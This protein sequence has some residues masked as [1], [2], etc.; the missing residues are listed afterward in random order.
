M[1]LSAIFVLPC[2]YNVLFLCLTSPMDEA[3]GGECSDP[4]QPW[5]DY[6]YIYY[7]QMLLVPI[8]PAPS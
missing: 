6:V 7:I 1:F 5:G 2:Y 8:K 4:H 3:K